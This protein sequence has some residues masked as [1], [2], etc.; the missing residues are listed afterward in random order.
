MNLLAACGT[1]PDNRREESEQIRNDVSGNGDAAT[2]E[3]ADV[4]DTT[5]Y[6]RGRE[7]PPPLEGNRPGKRSAEGEDESRGGGRRGNGGLYSP[8]ITRRRWRNGVPPEEWCLTRE[9]ANNIAM[10]LVTTNEQSLFYFLV[11]VMCCLRVRLVIDY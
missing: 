4:S 3:D 8:P 5:G 6:E 7:D 2:R 1:G 11:A 9:T 10:K